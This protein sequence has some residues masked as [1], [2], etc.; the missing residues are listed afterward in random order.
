LPCWEADYLAGKPG[1]QLT[2]TVNT[3][4]SALSG[5]FTLLIVLPAGASNGF[6]AKTYVA[7][8]S[9][10]AP[11]TFR[12][13]ARATTSLPYW[14]VP[15]P[16]PTVQSVKER[17]MESVVPSSYVTV[18]RVCWLPLT[19]LPRKLNL[20]AGVGSSMVWPVAEALS[21]R[22]AGEPGQV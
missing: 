9:L 6:V 2:A 16:P 7:T 1:V 10:S 12:Y 8:G 20:A 15:P 17:S 5:S 4:R 22:P 18:A 3:C 13:A 21:G 11:A 19:A 14:T